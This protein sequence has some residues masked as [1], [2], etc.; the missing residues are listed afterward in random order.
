MSTPVRWAFWSLLIAVSVMIIM[1]FQVPAQ[2]DSSKK[3]PSPCEIHYPSDATVEW[4][5]RALRPGE[6]LEKLFGGGTNELTK[7]LLLQ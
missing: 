3:H 4:G 6:S 1:V 5:C 7:G 2:A